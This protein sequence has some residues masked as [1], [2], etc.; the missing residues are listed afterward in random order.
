MIFQGGLHMFEL[1]WHRL[2]IWRHVA[3]GPVSFVFRLER[4]VPVRRGALV[5]LH[6][7]AAGHK[8][9][10]RPLAT[11]ANVQT[12]ESAGVALIVGVGPGFGHA[13][14]RRLIGE[15]F[16]LV[17]IGRNA[18]ALAPLAQE[19]AVSGRK[20]AHYGADATDELQVTDVFRRIERSHG[21]PTL[22]VYAVQKSGM[23]PVVD[24]TADAFEKAWRHNCFG[25]FLVA[26]A[27]ATAMKPVGAGTIVLVGCTSA[28]IGRADHLNLAVGKFGQRALAQVMAREMWPLGIHVAHVLI[29]A[30][31]AEPDSAPTGEP[32]S[33][34]DHIAQSLL[35][36]H[37]QPKTAWT[38]ELD[39]RPWNE[40]FWE[41]C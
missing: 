16:D 4:A 19:L 39:L 17:M 9:A 3:L 40:N 33:D 30:D 22:V 21:V 14:A 7:P 8:V 35:A 6:A 41:H 2:K 38:S 10:A 37:R 24:V 31:I 20:I 29:D 12:H 36:L 28:I 23:R 25:S 34:P 1:L 15:N 27:A 5:K 18:E 11:A 13:L 32:Q 26:R